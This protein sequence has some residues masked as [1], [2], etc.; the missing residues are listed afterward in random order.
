M[1][2]VDELN[3]DFRT[4]GKGYLNISCYRFCL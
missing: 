1:H 2:Q 4:K 3:I